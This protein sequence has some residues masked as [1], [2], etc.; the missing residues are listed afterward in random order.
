MVCALRKPCAS[1]SASARSQACARRRPAPCR[2][3]ARRRAA[4]AAPTGLVAVALAAR[5]AAV[6]AD[7]PQHRRAVLGEAREGAQLGRHLGRG[8]VGGAGHQRAD[9]GAQ[10]ARLVGI[11]GNAGRHQVAADVGEA[12]AE[13]AELVGELGDPLRRVLR[14]HHRDLEH[15]GP[16]PD[17]V[18]ERAD[19]ERAVVVLEGEQVERGEIARRVVEEHVLGA[20]VRGVDAAARRAGVPLVDRG[21]VLQAGIGAAPGGVGDL[22]PQ[23]ARRQAFGDAAVGAA[24]QLPVAVL[25]YLLEKV[26]GDPHAVVGVLAGDGEVGLRIPVGVEHREIDLRRRPG[27]RARCTRWMALSGIIALRAPRIARLSAGLRGDRSARPRRPQRRPGRPRITASR[28]RRARREPATSAAT[29]CSS[30][31]FQPMNCSMSGWSMSTTTIFAARRVVPPDLMAPAARS[32]I[33]QEA[34]QPGG[35]AAAGQRL[36]LAAQTR[37]VGAGAGAVLEQARLAD[38]QV[39]DPAL[40]DQVVGD[41]LDEAGVRLRPLVGGARRV[42]L[43]GLVVDEPVALRRAVDAVGPVQAGV[44]PLRRVRR[45]LLRRQH[46]AQ[47]V[48]EGARVRLAVEVAALPA[49]VGPGAGQPVEHLLGAALAAVALALGKPASAASSAVLPPQPSGH[50]VLA[51]RRSRAGTPALR[52]YFCASTSHATCDHAPAPPRHPGGTP[53][54]RPD[55]GSRCD[56]VRNSIVA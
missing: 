32:P 36:V 19:I 8:G 5:G 51:H 49:P 52:K 27:G 12:E 40:V 53:P 30:R 44:E 11:V 1:P 22:L 6:V 23:R 21:V 45:R 3:R 54:S 46:E 56:A 13:G 26:V 20:R 35:P 55:C 28:W 24:D 9:G 25:H 48:E 33:L 37:E 34:H 15:D 7:H 42:R 17:G 43:A 10:V 16:Q 18:P 38:P 14:H 29:F 31:T 47:L 4:P 41:A 39:H 2:G 50:A